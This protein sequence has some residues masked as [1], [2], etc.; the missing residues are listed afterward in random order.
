MRL[1]SESR[2]RDR[3]QLSEEAA[4]SPYLLDLIDGASSS[5]IQ[6]CDRPFARQGYRQTFR[7][8]RPS[9]LILAR[10]PATIVS[11]EVDGTALADGDW[12]LDTGRWHLFRLNSGA[13]WPWWGKVSVTYAGGWIVP[14]DPAFG[15]T[16]PA[17]RL[18]A[19]VE[20]AC[21]TLV[22]ARHA[23]RVR[24]PMLRSETTEGVGSASYIATADTGAMPPQVVDALRG[25]RSAGIS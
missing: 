19:D 23:G 9:A 17:E 12:D 25:Y 5:I 11:V 3:L 13:A 24:D 2:V 22:A 21:I 6:H 1:T 20:T 8:G 14:E 16:L 7:E 4:A 18:P 10:W 15:T